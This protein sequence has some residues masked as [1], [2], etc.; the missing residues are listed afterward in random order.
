MLPI[1]NVSRFLDEVRAVKQDN[2]E[3]GEKS[4][5]IFRGQKAKYQLVPSLIRYKE[6]EKIKL[7]QLEQL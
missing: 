2:I 3:Q 4:D 6:K 5:L 1:E 7:E